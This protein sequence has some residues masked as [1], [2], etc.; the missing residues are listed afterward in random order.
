[1]SKIKLAI[2]HAVAI[3]SRCDTPR[4]SLALLLINLGQSE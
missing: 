4:P 1:M 2:D 3:T